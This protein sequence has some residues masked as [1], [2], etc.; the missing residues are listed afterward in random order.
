MIANIVRTSLLCSLVFI[1][2]SITAEAPKPAVASTPKPAEAPKKSGPVVVELTQTGKEL[3]AKYT[4]ML[5]AL[6]AD[7]VK[8]VPVT[9]QAKVDAWRAAILAEEAPAKEAGAKANVVSKLQGAEGN[10]RELEE[11][12]RLAPNTIEDAKA[13]LERARARGEEDPEK[14]K[15]LASS[16]QWLKSRQKDMDKIS[17]QINAAK[18]SVEKA[19]IELPA[20]I[21]AAKVAKEAHEK[22]TAATWKA[23]DALGMNGILNSDKLDGK[24]AQFMV[25]KDATPKGLAEFAQQS[26]EHEKLVQA[27]LD[28]KEL[29]LQMLLADGPSNGKYGEAMKL[30]SDIQKACPKAKEGFFQRLALATSISHASPIQKRISSTAEKSGDPSY[31]D[32]MQRYLNYEKWYLAGELQP[33]FKDLSVWNLAY[34]VNSADPDEALAWVREMIRTMRPDCIPAGNDTSV[35]V[36]FVDKEVAYGSGE[37]TNDRPNLAFMQNVLANGGIC[38]RRGF[39]MTFALQAFGVPAIERIEPGHSTLGHWHPD[40]WQTRMGGNWGRGPKGY[41][42]MGGRARAYGSDVQFLASSQARENAAEFMKVKR[43]QWI[44]AV[45]GEPYKPGLVTPDAK[46]SKPG[47]TVKPPFW[48]DLALQEQRRIIANQKP[49]TRVLSKSTKAP[50]PVGKVT[51]GG[52]GVITIPAAACSNPTENQVF[53]WHGGLSDQISFVKDTTS[54]AVRVNL[55]RYA[56]E[57]NQVEYAFDAPKGGKYKLA[58]NAAVPKWN[59]R[60]IVTANGGTP[61]EM[62]LTYTI[63]LLGK[64]EPIMIELKAGKNVLKFHGPARVTVDKFTLTPAK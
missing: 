13:E 32:P 17:G 37:V 43:S 10:L 27:L 23:M 35:Y 58:A 16:E 18:A 54:G 21:E 64:S 51:V 28:N 6:K 12:L 5:N 7:L 59:N 31:I 24:F 1:G 56:K 30:Y 46:P 25:I 2:G 38:G 52:D 39:F 63:G 42:R 29:M 26:P 8:Q 53:L 44:A 61:V 4:G 41:G 15:I 20:A 22:A 49:W 34:A 45:A 50:G 62:P 47:E 3:E 40:G 19:K 55:S 14:Q 33:S 36:E 48:S 11:K 57:C 60:L 9:D